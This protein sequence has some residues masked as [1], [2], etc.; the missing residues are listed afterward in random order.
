ME[1]AVGIVPDVDYK[2]YQENG[3]ELEENKKYEKVVVTVYIKNKDKFTDLS[4]TMSNSFGDNIEKLSEPIG[5][6]EGENEEDYISFILN[7]KVEHTIC[8]KGTSLE[9]TRTKILNPNVEQHIKGPEVSGISLDK[10]EA[11]LTLGIE[12]KETITLIATIDPL[13]ADDKTVDWASSDNKVATVEDGIV[14]AVSV[15]T[16]TITATARGGEVEPATCTIVVNEIDKFGLIWEELSKIAQA[17]SK[18]DNIPVDATTA[19]VQVNGENK[20]VSVGEVYTLKYGTEEKD[21]RIIGL[22]HDKLADKEKKDGY[23]DLT[24]AG[25]TF[26]FVDSMNE[27]SP[28]PSGMSGNGTTGWSEMAVRQTL[29]GYTTTSPSQDEIDKSTTAG[30]IKNLSNKQYIKQVNKDYALST[31]N[32]S[33]TP[34]ED[35]LWLLSCTEIWPEEYTRTVRVF[36]AAKEGNQYPYYAQI[37]EGMSAGSENSNLVKKLNDSSETTYSWMLRSRYKTDY[38]QCCYVDIDGKCWAN[39]SDHYIVPGFCI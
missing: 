22:K 6:Q 31:S 9:G 21:V 16:V 20:T 26:N 15:G 39:W 19:T 5:V 27:S 24:Y 17:I 38:S 33:S 12:E 23:K 29:N 8:A 37:T 30:L 36:S 18:D 4:I 14:T 35:Y 2:L 13:D 28:Y 25:I 11:E 3:N 10:K 1:K 7:K 32:L 34:C